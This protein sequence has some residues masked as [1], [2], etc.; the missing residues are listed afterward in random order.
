VHRRIAG[1]ARLHVALHGRSAPVYRILAGAAGSDPEAAA[2][3]AEYSRER[4]AGQGGIA[5]SLAHDGALR[6]GLDERGAAD[7]IHALMSP[8]LYRLLVSERGWSPRRYERW[9]AGTL[10]DQLLPPR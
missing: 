4:D 10:A 9:L 2:L 1:F 5:R 6:A 7:I 3:L 8:E